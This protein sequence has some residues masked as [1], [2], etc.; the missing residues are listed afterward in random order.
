MRRLLLNNQIYLI[1]L[2]SNCTVSYVI[3]DIHQNYLLINICTGA[4]DADL[5]DILYFIIIL[6]NMIMMT[7]KLLDCSAHEYHYM[8]LQYH[9]EVNQPV[10]HSTYVFPQSVGINVSKNI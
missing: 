8:V 7:R 4:D 6:P 2:L 3:F 9:L 10:P 5:I 1:T